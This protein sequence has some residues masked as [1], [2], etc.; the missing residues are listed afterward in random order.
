MMKAASTLAFLLL[1]QTTDGRRL[2]QE[3][4]LDL[5]MEGNLIDAPPSMNRATQESLIGMQF[6]NDPYAGRDHYSMI[7][8]GELNLSGLRYSPHSFKSIHNGDYYDVHGEFCV[9]DPILN[10]KDPAGYATASAIMNES[11]HCAEHRYTLPL[12]EVMNAIKQAEGTNKN[13]KTLPVSGLIFHE[14][15][16]GAGLISNALAIF[17]SNLV[18]AEH[19]GKGHYYSF[20]I[21]Q[22]GKINC[23]LPPL[24]YS[25][26]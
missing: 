18:V 22:L 2:S 9:Y 1:A 20:F 25:I 15:Y 7:V 23:N 10:R 4:A 14:G 24:A 13:M 3:G 11:E 21:L 5:D 16:S 17:E 6:S 26:T 8:N 19:T 12:H